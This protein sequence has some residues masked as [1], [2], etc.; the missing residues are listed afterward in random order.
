M[1]IQKSFTILQ[2]ITITALLISASLG[3]AHHVIAQSGY[4]RLGLPQ[5]WSHHH[6]VFSSLQTQNIP[7]LMKVRQDPRVLH[8]WLR[9][10][11]SVSMRTN[12]TSI[13]NLVNPDAPGLDRPVDRVSDDWSVSLGAANSFVTR[14][15]FPAKY[16]FDI[17][18]PPDC[19]NDYVVF[20]TRLGGSA[21]QATII[22]F[23]HLYSTQGSVGG[24]CNQNGPSIKWSYNTARPIRSSPVLSLDGT[25]VAWVDFNPGRVH[26]LT[27]GT[28]GANGSSVTAPVIPGAGNNAVDRSLTLNGAPRV[29]QSALFVDYRNDVAYVGDDAGVLHKIT[30]IFNGT[31]AELTTSGWPIHVTAAAAALTGPTFD[32][33]TGNIF[34]ADGSGN[35]SYVRE[36]GSTVGACASGAPPCLGFPAI[37]VSPGTPILD[38]PVVDSVTGRVFTE[39]AASGASAQ[40]IQADAALG[41]VVRVN[42]GQQDAAHPLHSGAFDQNYLTSVSTGF[43]YVCGKAAGTTN[44]TLYRI[45]FNSLGVL[46]SAPD[47]ATLGLAR[48]AAEC[49]PITEV[50]NTGSVPQKDW[51]FVAVSTRCGNTPVLPN[52]C[53]MSYDITSGMPGALTAAVLERNGTSGIIIDNVSTAAQ[54]SNIYFTN[55]G[56]GACGDGIATGGCA[57]KLTQAGLK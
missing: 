16:S 51:L 13:L 45:G 57:V 31:P 28:T 46:N 36:L 54:A 25:K 43:Y 44:P 50:F 55:Q 33:T 21:T 1:K 14:N 24:L 7:L 30:G 12:S 53:V 34:V 26:V 5:D 9:H 4:T 37:A 20:P 15:H 19:V 47:A 23:N 10:N 22:A 40:I 35:L 56:T 17:N 48:A 49:S 52:G 38:A 32:S 6:V 8:Q 39:T 27:V 3:I 42:V 2:R 11:A 29:T 18:A 41:N